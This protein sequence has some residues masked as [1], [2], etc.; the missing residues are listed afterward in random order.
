MEATKN[1]QQKTRYE[2][3]PVEALE[4]VAKVLTYGAIK[5]EDN[6]WRKGMTWSRVFGATLRHLWAF[7]RGE[8]FD[9]EW[10]LSHLDHALCELMFLSTYHK[11]S[12][13]EDDR[14]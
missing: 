8:D 4:G 11:T 12:T 5:Y 9:D 3:L 10:G 13:G 14:P 2:L 1:D 7:W 6:N